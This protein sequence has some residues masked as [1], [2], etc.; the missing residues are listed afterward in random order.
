MAISFRLLIFILDIQGDQKGLQQKTAKNKAL[1][2]HV[3]KYP[4]QEP[5]VITDAYVR[6]K[7]SNTHSMSSV[8]ND[9]CLFV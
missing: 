8:S 7:N 9:R 5:Q 2:F 1:I 3:I 6:L 4:W